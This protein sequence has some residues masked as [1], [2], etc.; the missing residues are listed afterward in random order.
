MQ[1]NGPLPMSQLVYLLSAKFQ[2]RLSWNCLTRSSADDEGSPMWDH[3]FNSASEEK[4]TSLSLHKLAVGVPTSC[5]LPLTRASLLTVCDSYGPNP[6]HDNLL[7]S[8]QLCAGTHCLMRLE[9]LTW[10]D[11]VSLRDYQ[12]V[13][14][15]HSVESFNNVR[16]FWL[17]GHKADQFFEGN[18][19]IIRK[20][21]AP[22]T[23]ALFDAYPASQDGR[24]HA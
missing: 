18:R 14:M 24:F 21:S 20:S 2:L 17:P 13:S 22:D 19:L 10:P 16:S 11:R 9:E 7:F 15:R 3:I 23:C 4:G 12:K 6:S 5:K 8:T 1:S